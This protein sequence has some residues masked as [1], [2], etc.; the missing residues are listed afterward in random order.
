MLFSNSSSVVAL[1]LKCALEGDERGAVAIDAQE[2]EREIRNEYLCRMTADA[3]ALLGRKDDALRWL[4][5]A[6]DGGFINYP[7]L[8]V[9]DVF[10]ESMRTEPQFEALMA[11]VKPRWKAVVEWERGLEV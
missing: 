4:G 5:A 11:E 7:N 9:H 2:L 1:F 6:I 3:C 8:T 10:L